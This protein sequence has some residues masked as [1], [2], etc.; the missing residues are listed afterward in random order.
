MFL[1]KEVVVSP[2]QKRNKTILDYLLSI[3][4]WLFAVAIIYHIIQPDLII[5]N[6]NVQSEDFKNLIEAVEFIPIIPETCWKAYDSAKNLK[7][8]IFKSRTPGYCGIIPITVGIDASGKIT[9]IIIGGEEEGFRETEG[10]GAKVRESYFLN[11]LIGKY[12]SQL[13]LKKDSGE[14]DAICGATISSQAVCDGIRKSMVNYAVYLLYPEPVD[15]RFNVFPEAKEFIPIIDGVLWY[16]MKDFDT[17]GIVFY[18]ATM[19]YR[20]TIKFIAGIDREAKI[21]GIEILSSNETAGVGERIREREFLD[22]FKQ[23][24]PETISGATISSRA[25]IDKVKEDIEVYK[26]YLK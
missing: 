9:G 18:D 26:K 14:I 19:G 25:L 20:D 23:K 6:K 7:G 4:V 15:I 16:A 22:Q 12:A 5:A 13:R 8:I 1:V 3:F 2:L 21:R 17:I 24:I 10:L 11:Q